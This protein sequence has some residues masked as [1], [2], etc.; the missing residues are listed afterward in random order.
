M[1][2]DELEP[3]F[4]PLSYGRATSDRGRPLSISQIKLVT[5]TVG[6]TPEVMVKVVNRGSSSLAGVGRHVG[7]IGR[8]GEVALETDEGEILQGQEVGNALLEDWNLDL[9]KER[10]KINL[11]PNKPKQ[12]PRLVYKLIFSM[13]AGTPPEKV[14]AAV[15]NFAREEFALRHR[16][17]MALHTDEPHPHVHL[18]LKATSDEGQRLYIRKAMLREWRE[19]FASHL[20]ALGVAANATPRYVRGEITSQKLDGVYRAKARGESTHWQKRVEAVAR[21]LSQGKLQVESGK[22]KLLRTRKEVQRVWLTLGDT[23]ARQGHSEIAAQVR[24]Y[25]AEMP[26]PLTEKE[27]IATILLEHVRERKIREIEMAR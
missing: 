7:Y 10:G 8:Q 22:T 15:R 17:V 11:T 26:K 23:L 5:R 9:I 3:L 27:Y 20:R 19:G 2:D 14:Q 13:P 25:V 21:E 18:V 4:D 16:Y 1:S 24:R 12:P 6:R